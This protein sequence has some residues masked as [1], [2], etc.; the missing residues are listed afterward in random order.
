MLATIGENIKD[1][2]T[3]NPYINS[4]ENVYKIVTIEKNGRR[5]LP[6]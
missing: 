1:L 3:D 4:L 2:R 6:K 5:Y